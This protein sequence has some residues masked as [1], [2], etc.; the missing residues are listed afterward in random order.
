MSASC[1]YLGQWEGPGVADD[2]LRMRKE[3]AAK[4]IVSG[5]MAMDDPDVEART[6]QG[7]KM[8]GLGSDFGLLIRAMKPSLLKLKEKAFD[9]RWF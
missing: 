7:F 6:E 3:A 5:I 2:I 9:K 4:N 8:V 1:G